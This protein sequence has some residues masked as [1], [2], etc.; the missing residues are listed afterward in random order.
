MQKM[1]VNSFQH[2]LGER[3]TDDVKLP[4]MLNHR[5]QKGLGWVGW[6]WGVFFV[7]KCSFKN[8]II[9]I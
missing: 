2:G 3:L 7:C 8:H 6:V 1:G 5:D 9:P 4:G